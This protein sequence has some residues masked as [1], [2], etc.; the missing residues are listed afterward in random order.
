MTEFVLRGGKRLRPRLALASYRILTGRLEPPP[1]P[2]WLTASSLELF[3]AFMLVHDDLIDESA[4]RRGN[5]TLHE[6]I[7]TD[8]NASDCP[9]DRKKAS[10]LGLVAGDLLFALGMRMVGRSGLEDAAFGRAQRLLSDML[11]ETGLGEALDILF[12]D[13]PLANIGEAEIIDAYFRKTARYTISGPLRLGAT[14]AGADTSVDRTLRHFGDLLGLGYQ[15][16]N[17]LD[18]LDEGND[19]ADLVGGKKTWLLWRAYHRS[20]EAKRRKI[21]AALSAPPGSERGRVLREAIISS[22]AI[23]DCRERLESLREE[24]A[25][26][27]RESSLDATQRKS[28]LSLAKLFRPSHQVLPFDA[29]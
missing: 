22:D 19:P 3:H 13:C 26:T 20:S 16:Q 27:L 9:V 24:A 12:G 28:F 25:T 8:G 14:L 11:F 6:T 21:E 10:D 29:S 5:P 23:Q 1:R 18:A 4:T 17:D 15:M 2:I 7:R